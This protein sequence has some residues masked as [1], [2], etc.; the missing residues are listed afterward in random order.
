MP[1]DLPATKRIDVMVGI[2]RSKVIIFM[3]F[4][5]LYFTH[6]LPII[7]SLSTHHLPIIYPSSTHYL[8]I[9]YPSSTHYIPII[10]S[11]STHHLPIIYPSSTH[12][13][14]I[15]YSLST[16]H[17]P[18]SYPLYTNHL[19]LIYLSSI[20]CI[21]YIHWYTAPIHQ[22]QLGQG[23]GLAA[24]LSAAGR[25]IG[26]GHRDSGTTAA[27]QGHVWWSDPLLVEELGFNIW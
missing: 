13:L 22:F 24:L 11:L 16:H 18:I 2:T 1:E 4:S 7:Y 5:H 14:P 23:L 3:Y 26:C 19:P 15:I 10:Y 27:G 9:I 8:P 25:G 21:R 12:Y 17:L 6:Y 20:H